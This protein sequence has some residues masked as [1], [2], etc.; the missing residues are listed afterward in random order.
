M[1]SGVWIPEIPEI[2][3]SLPNWTFPTI[4]SV[5][6]VFV[7]EEHPLQGWVV[8]TITFL[9][10][11]ESTLKI[12]VLCLCN[13]RLLSHIPYCSSPKM[14]RGGRETDGETGMVNLFFFKNTLS[15]YTQER[16]SF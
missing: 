1:Y 4:T 5:P 9:L 14:V 15:E 16:G 8:V 11:D 12:F 3:P 13:R 10:T 2:Q 7:K 6:S